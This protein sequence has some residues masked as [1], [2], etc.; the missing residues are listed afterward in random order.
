MLLGADFFLSHHVYVANDQRKLYFTYNGGPVFNLDVAP[1]VQGGAALPTAAGN[2]AVEPVNAADFARRGTA[3][4]SRHEYDKAIADLT[5]AAEL[6]PTDPTYLFERARAYE[7][8]HQPFL[9]MAD[10][11]KS[12]A[13]K[14]DDVPALTTRAAFHLAGRDKPHA[15]ADLAAAD[16]LAARQADVRLELAE[17]YERADE[18]ESAVG[19]FDLWIATHPEDSRQ[20]TALSQRCFTRAVWNHALD[21]ALADCDAALKRDPKLVAARESRGLVRLR[22]GDPDAAA[23]DFDAALAAQPKD[24]WALYGRGLARLKKG[25]TADGK[26]DLAAAGALR[27][28]LDA[29]AKAHG[30]AP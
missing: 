13:L 11:D 20:A 26:A 9:A 22:Q 15:L 21:L 29:E 6:A 4:A 25:Q 7:G 5:R 14:P 28:G 1:T 10:L 16:R 2:G 24:P 19:Q 3:F 30:L 8:N 17:L 18:P 12:L 27:P 23:A